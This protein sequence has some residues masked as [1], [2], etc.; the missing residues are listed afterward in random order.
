M[1]ERVARKYRVAFICVRNS[2]RSQVAEALT[3][4]LASDTI[5]PLSGGAGPS[6]TVDPGAVEAM[7]EIGIDI[8]SAR[9][10]QLLQEIIESL[11]LVLRM[12]CGAPG[13]CMTVPGVPSEGWGIE[14]PVGMSRDDYRGVVRAI[15]KKVRDPAVRL[16]AG[17]VPSIS[18]SVTFRLD[19]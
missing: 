13:M 19:L 1:G 5:E 17:G 8:S 7:D 6:E 15:D 10:K 3:R 18:S 4:D 9:P 14:D 2:C 16:R 11:D 12:G